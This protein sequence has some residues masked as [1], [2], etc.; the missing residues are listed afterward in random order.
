MKPKM[1]IEHMK[2]SGSERP[3]TDLLKRA[4]LKMKIKHSPTCA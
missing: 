2:V 1:E 3:S 4:Q